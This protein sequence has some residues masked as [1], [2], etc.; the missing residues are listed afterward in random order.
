MRHYESPLKVE[1]LHG[2]PAELP[3]DRP[4]DLVTTSS[5]TS[6][7]PS[8]AAAP[9]LRD[10]DATVE[11]EYQTGL[12]GETAHADALQLDPAKNKASTINT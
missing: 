12:A 9:V 7:S 3:L 10:E 11:G 5:G 1:Q 8:A 4:D 6:S 2:P